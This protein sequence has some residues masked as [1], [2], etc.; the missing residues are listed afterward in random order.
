LIGIGVFMICYYG[1][2]LLDRIINTITGIFCIGIALFPT[3]SSD[4]TYPVGIFVLNQGVS[5]ILHVICASIFF[6]LL[7]FISIFLF[8]KTA[9]MKRW[10]PS[11]KEEV[12]TRMTPQKKIRNIIYIVCGVIILCCGIALGLVMALVPVAIVNKYFIVLILEIIILTAF[13]ISWLIKGGIVI[14]DK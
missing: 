5:N 13:G 12:F 8:T 10:Q 14:N 3:Q 7:G 6:A 1:Y 4:L 11:G 9:K 2:D